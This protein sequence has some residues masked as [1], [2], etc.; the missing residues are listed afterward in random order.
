MSQFETLVDCEEFRQEKS[1]MST[2]RY[3]RDIHY[4]NVQNETLLET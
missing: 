2:S 1:Q 4:K 3:C